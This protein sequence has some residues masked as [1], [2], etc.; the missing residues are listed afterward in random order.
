MFEHFLYLCAPLFCVAL[1]PNNSTDYL[2]CL[3]R[4]CG[5]ILHL[6]LIL[7]AAILDFFKPLKVWSTGVFTSPVDQYFATHVM[8]AH[9]S[10]NAECFS[11]Y[12]IRDLQGWL[13]ATVVLTS[14]LTLDLVRFSAIQKPSYSFSCTFSVML[15]T[16]VGGCPPLPH[17][18]LRASAVVIIVKS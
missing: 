9:S 18:F 11:S 13:Q 6:F 16:W 2:I 14:Y 3:N 5:P 8:R 12:V 10:F 15:L 17:P 1:T 4:L 7:V